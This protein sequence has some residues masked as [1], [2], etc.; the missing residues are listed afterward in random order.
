MLMALRE[1]LDLVTPYEDVPSLRLML[2]AIATEPVLD[3]VLAAGLTWAMHSSVAVVLLVVSL[4]A[5]GVVPPEAAF[6]LVL[7]ANLGTAINPCI[8]GA[9]GDDP[10]ARRLPVGNLLNRLAAVVIALAAIGPVGRFMVTLEPDNSRVVADFHTLFNLVTAA[11]SFPLLPAIARGLKRLLPA[12]IDPADPSMPQYLDP[13]ARETP[14]VALGGAAREALRLADVLE[15]MLTSLRD[16]LEK[17]DRR[18]V[19]QTRRLDD[20]LDKLDTAIKS[21]LTTLDTEAMTEGDHRRVGDILAFSTNIEAAGDVVDKDLLGLT[22]KK[23][24]R[25]VSFPKDSQIELVA[26]IDRL[27][28]NIRTAAT[29]FMTED[30]RAARLLAAEKEAFRELA[31]H[32]TSAHFD[33][34]RRTGPPRPRQARCIWTR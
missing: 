32:A 8:E 28:A 24:K 5:K 2:G 19:A 16:L 13:A 12:R 7:G 31:T 34:L 4:A 23:I 25:G 14:V 18:R 22:A 20:V 10:A 21:Y 1:L 9:A 27:L 29:V 33:R 11:I 17:D 3:V 15:A 30:I 26:A 6:A